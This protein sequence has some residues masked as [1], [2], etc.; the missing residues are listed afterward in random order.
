MRENKQDDVSISFGS[1]RS[2]G[3]AWHPTVSSATVGHRPFQGD[4]QLDNVLSYVFIY[5]F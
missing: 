4:Y 5:L 2:N 1:V 3:R